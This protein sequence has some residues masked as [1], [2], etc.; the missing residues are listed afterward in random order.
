MITAE[1]PIVAAADLPN[2]RRQDIASALRTIARDR[3]MR[4]SS[5]RISKRRTTPGPP[6]AASPEIYNIGAEDQ[7]LDHIGAAVE[8]AI[9][10]DAG[11]AADCFDDLG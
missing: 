8:A 11:A 5:S 2:R 1:R 10:H 9:D 4:I 3:Q 6:A 7:R